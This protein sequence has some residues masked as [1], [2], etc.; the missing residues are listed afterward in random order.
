MAMI[1][2]SAKT[3]CRATGTL[4]WAAELLA[5]N[6]VIR[7]YLTHTELSR[8]CAVQCKVNPLSC[9]CISTIIAVEFMNTTRITDQDVTVDVKLSL[10]SGERQ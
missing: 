10:E 6:L 7:S 9:A 4:H 5:Q 1:M 8:E 3:I 2:I